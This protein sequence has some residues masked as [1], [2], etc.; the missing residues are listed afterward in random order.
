MN[1]NDDIIRIYKLYRCCVIFTRIRRIIL[2]KN[3]ETN[4]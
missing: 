3:L 4:V 1:F 2:E